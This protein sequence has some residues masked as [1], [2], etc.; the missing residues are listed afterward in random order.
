MSTTVVETANLAAE[1]ERA[2]RKHQ[3]ALRRWREVRDRETRL[4]TSRVLTTDQGDERPIGTE[5]EAYVLA[6]EGIEQQKREAAHALRDARSELQAAQVAYGNQELEKVTAGFGRAVELVDA[7]R[8]ELEEVWL[9]FIV[10]CW[11]LGT[12]A[13]EERRLAGV[14]AALAMD[15]A[16]DD[17]ARDHIRHALRH[18]VPTAVDEE[19]PA[20]WVDR[21][22]LGLFGGHGNDMDPRRDSFWKALAQLAQMN[23]ERALTHVGK[24]IR[25]RLE[26]V[27][28]RIEEQQGKTR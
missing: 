28:N 6:R 3:E 22:E 9:E 27:R 24:H 17:Q 7:R 26:R 14:L 18:R 2:R 19:G 1:L 15:A 5:P 23:P 4:A 16:P 10:R 12:A 11:G 21:A 8:G 20:A 25:G 13:A